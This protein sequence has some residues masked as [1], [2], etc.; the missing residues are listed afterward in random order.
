MKRK[1]C[2]ER[3]RRFKMLQLKSGCINVWIPGQKLWRSDPINFST[4]RTNRRSDRII[5]VLLLLA[6]W[7]SIR[8]GVAHLN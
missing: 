4:L 3:H 5:I 6:C 7:I 1:T 8:S 2:I